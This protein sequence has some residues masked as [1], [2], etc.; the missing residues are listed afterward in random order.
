M[1]SKCVFLYGLQWVG[2]FGFACQ[3]KYIVFFYESIISMPPLVISH[4]LERAL[5]WMEMAREGLSWRVKAMTGYKMTLEGGVLI[6][7]VWWRS[8]SHEKK[9]RV[10]CFFIIIF[11]VSVCRGMLCGMSDKVSYFYVLSSEVTTMAFRWLVR[12][13][14][15]KLMW[16][17]GGCSENLTITCNLRCQFIN[18]SIFSHYWLF[19]HFLLYLIFRF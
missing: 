7:L 2:Y 17:C 19:L 15:E 12:W 1:T 18:K 6:L 5:W 14:V 9:E 11:F 10:L 16:R 4:L 13:C 3:L 8:S